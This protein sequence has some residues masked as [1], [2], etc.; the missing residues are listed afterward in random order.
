[1]QTAAQATC[2]MT[3]SMTAKNMQNTVKATLPLTANMRVHLLNATIKKPTRMQLM[4]CQ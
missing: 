1:M 4:W 2:I 3:P